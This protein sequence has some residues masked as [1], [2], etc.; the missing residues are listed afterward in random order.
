MSDIGPIAAV[1]IAVLL[2]LFATRRKVGSGR[3]ARELVEQGA[4]LLDVRTPAEFAAK[5]LPGAINIPIRELEKRVDELGPNTT[6]VVI[7]CR[8][9]NRSARAKSLLKKR[10]FEQV[11]DLG[12]MSA[13]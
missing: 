3:E 6:S 4:T 13:W 10:G 12:A 7:Y 1:V 5:H 9:G 11:Y 8:S 2:L